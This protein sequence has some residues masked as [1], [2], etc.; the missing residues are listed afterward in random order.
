MTQLLVELDGCS[1]G[2]V[3]VATTN[4]VSAIDP[5]IT[6][7]GRIE[8]VMA[9]VHKTTLSLNHFKQTLTLPL[10]DEAARVRILA[11]LRERGRWDAAVDVP[12]IAR[13]TAGSRFNCSKAISITHTAR[14]DGCGPGESGKAGGGGGSWTKRRHT[15]HHTCGLYSSN[16]ARGAQWLRMAE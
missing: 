8:H 15:L 16:Q 14:P 11:R 13:A 4:D 12:A 7:A 2:V 10:P 9:R 6:R 5:A 1:P 3:V